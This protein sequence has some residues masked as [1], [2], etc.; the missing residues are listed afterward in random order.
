MKIAKAFANESS[1]SGEATII[2]VLPNAV[3]D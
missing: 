3:V 2:P 1:V